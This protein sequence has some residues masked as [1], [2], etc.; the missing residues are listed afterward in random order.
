MQ[1]VDHAPEDFKAPYQMGRIQTL[2]KE[3]STQVL[4]EAIAECV[5][6]AHALL[7]TFLDIDVDSLRGLPVFSFVRT[8][9][10][11]FILAKLSLSCA[12][13]SSRIGKVL[14]RSS[15]QLESYMDRCSKSLSASRL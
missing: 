4:A 12:D 6:S 9:F 10:A 2:G 11:S 1:H 7:T 3:V 8:S 15:L 5:S 13:P 14:D